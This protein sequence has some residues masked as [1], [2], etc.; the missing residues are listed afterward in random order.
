MHNILLIRNDRFGEFLLNIPVF[1][2]FKES[3]KDVE[4]TLAVDSY[5]QDLA[6][7]IEYVDDVIVWDNRKHTLKEI[8]NFSQVLRKKKFKTCLVLNPAKDSHIASFLAGIPKRAGYRRKWDFLLNCTLEDTKAKALKHEVEYNLLLTNL[9][10]ANTDDNSLNLKTDPK[11]ALDLFNKFSIAQSD[12]LIAI[13]PFTSDTIKQW[14]K[15]KFKQLISVLE[16]RFKGKIIIVGGK[17]ELD[18]NKSFLN[19]LGSNVINLTGQTSLMQLAAV[20]KGCELLISCD[21]GPMHLAAAVNTKVVAIFRSDIVAKSAR[22]W[23]PWGKGHIVI[24]KDDLRKIE[25]SDVFN[26]LEDSFSI[27]NSKV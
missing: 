25:V 2:A 13:H 15:E 27:L 7:E 26:K 9:L 4:L 10:G 24:A 21:S 16:S 5:V 1:R 8:F 17:N 6:K 22:R 12:K 19:S 3:F 14:P 23:G 11:E 18:E 20:I